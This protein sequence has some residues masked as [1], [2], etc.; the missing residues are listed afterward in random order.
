MTLFRR[1]TAVQRM[2][3]RIKHLFPEH[4]HHTVNVLEDSKSGGFYV[5]VE[6]SGGNSY[7]HISASG[8]VKEVDKN[9]EILVKI[10]GI[11][12]VLLSGIIRGGIAHG[13]L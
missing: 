3:E 9:R 10:G 4:G 8:I 7:F 11:G 5:E 1:K 2:K 12:A 6:I 13:K